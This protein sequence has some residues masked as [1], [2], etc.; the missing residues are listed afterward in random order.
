MNSLENRAGF[1]ISSSKLQVVEINFESGQFEL[2]NV[3]EA[4]FNEPLNL[5]NDKE[6]KIASV[7]Q[8]RFRRTP[9]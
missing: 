1:N 8:G 3:D 9:C 4:Y 2:E 5:E 7:L 6:T